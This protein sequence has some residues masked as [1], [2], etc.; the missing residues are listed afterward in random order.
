M[1]TA[2][3]FNKLSGLN[4][5]DGQA[6]SGS[7]KFQA[8][9][10]ARGESL[11]PAFSQADADLVHTAGRCAGK[12]FA[13]FANCSSA[14]R[15]EL[16]GTIAARL[17]AI[18]PALI[19]RAGL[20]SALPLPRLQ[21][22]L[23]RTCGQLRLFAQT[24]T[25]DGDGPRRS[26]PADPDRQ[27][28][29]RPELLQQRLPIGPVA[30]FGASNFPLAFSVAGGDTAAAL[31]AGCPVVVKAHPAHPGTSELA[32]Q[33]IA[34]ALEDL[35]LPAGVFALLQSN[36]N[37]V[38]ADLVRHPD[39]AA[40]GFTGSLAGGRA[41]CDVAAA[42]PDPIP[43]FAEMG[44][45]NPVFLLPGAL[46]R[47]GQALAQGFAQSLL[48]GEG[49]FCTNPGLL[50]AVA[51]EHLDEFVATSATTLS[52]H[53]PATMLTPAIR[54][55]YCQN[56]D[57]QQSAQ[58]VRVAARG[59]EPEARL[60]QARSAISRVSVEHFLD[61]PSLQDEVF[62]P[63]SLLVE[64]R[65]PADLQ[66]VA[67]SLRGQLTATV[68]GDESDRELA[69]SLTRCLQHKAGRILFDG[70]PTGVEVSP[71]MVHGGPWPASSAAGTTSVGTRA[72]ERFQRWVCF[73]DLP[74]DWQED[75][76]HGP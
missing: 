11:E 34:D 25:E 73:Q 32:G 27:P 15:A 62:G 52:A 6:V 60:N 41:L 43:V 35:D 44:S 29:P 51:G 12:A 16:L 5:I 42:R 23:G 58:G 2:S 38:A 21:G 63:A 4:L 24:L 66:V 65:K 30:V 36:R 10:P 19:E 37:E 76:E 46:A 28:L 59:A 49:Q 9:D 40:V 64:C 13:T 48:M 57:R 45:I 39:I 1:P 61:D 14:K 72:M 50:V 31:A 70:F 22:E 71:A 56:R 8:W 69:V 20:E 68:H 54:D 74:K 26:I 55:A 17:E 33:A 47:R 7:G 53:Q 18:G 67:E 75:L 3:R